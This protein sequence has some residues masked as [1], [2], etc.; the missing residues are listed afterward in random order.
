MSSCATNALLDITI[1]F[2]GQLFNV[3]NSDVS[4]PLPTVPILL[5]DVICTGS[6]T[7]LVQ[8]SHN[9]FNEHNCYHY[10]DVV[11]ECVGKRGTYFRL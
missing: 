3:E 10:E 11:V 9:G 2:L 1:L 8:C 4:L 7:S 6:E 5:D